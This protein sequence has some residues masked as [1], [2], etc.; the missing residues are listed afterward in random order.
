M[1]AVLEITDIRKTFGGLKAVDGLGLTIEAGEVVGLLGPNGSGKTTL[2]NLVSGALKPTEGSIRLKGQEI[3]GRRPDVIA[4]AGVARTFQLVRL[5]PSL[6]LLENVA[7][8]AMFGPQRLSRIEAEKVARACL[9]RI[10]LAGRETMPAGDLTYIDE[11]R[12][13]LARALAGEPKLLLLDEWLAG[14]N[15]TELQEGIA[16][17]RRLASEGTTIL[18]VEHIMAAVHALCPRSVVMAAGRK[19]ADGPT[20]TVLDDPQVISAYLGAAH[21]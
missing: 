6:S 5:L 20:A 1:S 9:E 18:L 16:L 17:I 10:G 7:V 12:L 21:A 4:R 13:E 11:K 8:S 19:I 3:A 2:M 14:L 15:P